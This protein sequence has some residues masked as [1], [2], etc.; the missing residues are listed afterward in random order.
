VFEA[1]SLWGQ[2]ITR[3]ESLVVRHPRSK[4]AD[5]ANV[6]RGLAL[7]RL[8]Q[9]P[10][11]VGP[12]GRVTLLHETGD[13]TEESSLALGRCQIELGDAAQ[14]DLAFVRLIDSRDP[15]RRREARFQ[16]ARALRL[17]E[18]YEDA[19]AVLRES[20]DPRASS[21]LLLSLAGAGRG[22]EALAVADS[23]VASKDTAFVWDSVIATLGRRDP[24]VASA[25]VERLQSD[26]RATP[27]RRASRLYED[28]VRLVDVDTA[29]AVVR[30]QQ[31]A[32]MEGRT[33][34]GERARLRLLRL[35]LSAA[36]TID[37]LAPH[38]DSLAALVA[39]GSTV[40][41]E[42]ATLQ[43][44]VARL[45]LLADSA[46]PG[47]P[48]GDLRLFLGAEEARDAVGA[49][50]LAAALFRRL[51]DEWPASPYA[52]KALLAVGRLVP[53]DAEG[54]RARLD[55]LYQDSPYL[56]MVR[57]ED[58]P[59]YGVLEDSLQAFA[60]TQTATGRR[61][62]PPSVRRR[63]IE[64]D[65]AGGRGRRRDRRPADEDTAHP[66]RGLEP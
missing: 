5:E 3:A 14:A 2:V 24:R 26:P 33:D 57:G 48:Q 65:K 23:L 62:L 47:V 39:R 18:R 11:A 32:T 55:S 52:P 31:A 20:P 13:L 46:S 16:H 4:Y 9:C 27:E 41:P 19:L 36:R 54:V 38:T 8:Q 42:A 22:D 40:A 43:T 10:A 30:F 45:R 6:L 58:P 50:A 29:R 28:A 66:R 49:P 37:D 1:Q 7:A 12:L 44:S 21:D 63:L 56:A 61:Q 64:E 60:L 25:L 35:A 59:A 15:A 51:A 34:S 53:A 17:T